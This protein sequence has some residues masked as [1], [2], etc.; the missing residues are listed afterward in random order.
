MVLAN[1][2]QGFLLQTIFK[3][4]TY[5]IY[6]FERPDFTGHNG[7]RFHG[8][9]DGFHYWN[10][11]FFILGHYCKGILRTK[12]CSLIPLHAAFPWCPWLFLWALWLHSC[13]QDWLLSFIPAQRDTVMKF[14]Q[15]FCFPITNPTMYWQFLCRRLM[16]WGAAQQF[17]IPATQ[18]LSSVPSPDRFTSQVHY[19]PFTLARWC[20]RSF[21]IVS[22]LSHLLPSCSYSLSP[23]QGS[24]QCPV[25]WHSLPP[26]GRAVPGLLCSTLPQHPSSLALHPFSVLFGKVLCPGLVF[27]LFFFRFLPGSNRPPPPHLQK[28]YS[29]QRYKPGST[30]CFVEVVTRNV[31]YSLPELSAISFWVWHP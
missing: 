9:I 7:N 11:S 17:P 12:G 19:L 23:S 25:H 5:G 26:A 14:F 24:A 15:C 16:I 29:N 30:S 13:F 22:W 28:K 6:N 10:V 31:K 3:F 4:L 18:L 20:H 21:L 8:I 1:T 27:L 2:P